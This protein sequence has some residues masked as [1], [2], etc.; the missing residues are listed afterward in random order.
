[1]V[2]TPQYQPPTKVCVANRLISEKN[3]IMYILNFVCTGFVFSF[4]RSVPSILSFLLIQIF[5]WDSDA[6]TSSWASGE[7]I[8]CCWLLV[9]MGQG[10]TE[11]QETEWLERLATNMSLVPLGYLW[12][13]TIFILHIHKIILCFSCY[14]WNSNIT[15]KNW[16]TCTRQHKTWLAPNSVWHLC[17]G[18]SRNF[19]LGRGEG[20]PNFGSERTVKRFCGKLLSPHTPSHQSL[21]RRLRVFQSVK[22]SSRWRGKYC[23]ASRGEQI[24]D[25]T[26]RQ[27]HFLIPLEFILMAKYNTRFNKKFS[28][29]NSDIRSY[30][31]KHFSLKQV[32]GGSGP[33]DPPSGSATALVPF[34]IFST[35]FGNPNTPIASYRCTFWT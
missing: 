7:L 8:P 29:L 3:G 9:G 27:S 15:R 33:P 26:Q 31:C 14:K 34:D 32:S 19:L 35:A 4:R 18:G 21:R 24:T 23:L 17:R 22:S 1:M 25:G 13:G 6:A 12:S 11:P 20:G 30:R 5:F 28:Q 2:T 10:T 16:F